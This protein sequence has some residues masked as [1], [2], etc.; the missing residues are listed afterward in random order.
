MYILY[1]LVDTV[2][3]FDLSGCSSYLII[4]SRLIQSWYNWYIVGYLMKHWNRQFLYLKVIRLKLVY[5][6][7]DVE[8]HNTILIL[9]SIRIPTKYLLVKFYVIYLLY[10]LL[11]R[12]WYHRVMSSLFVLVQYRNSWVFSVGAN[13]SVS[14]FWLCISRLWRL[15]KL[16]F[17]APDEWR[18]TWL[19]TYALPWTMGLGLGWVP[20]HGLLRHTLSRQWI[21]FWIIYF[22]IEF[23]LNNSNRLTSRFWLEDF[24][25]EKMVIPVNDKNVSCCKWQKW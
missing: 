12:F 17:A 11:A 8:F 3:D 10:V 14:K 21:L 13:F 16:V 6:L 25:V 24:V 2:V 4:I 19:I 5:T 22:K 23:T 15:K 1:T 20:F 18:T 7:I 9:C